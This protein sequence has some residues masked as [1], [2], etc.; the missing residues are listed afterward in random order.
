VTTRNDETATLRERPELRPPGAWSFPVPQT[1]T[2]ATGLAVQAYH[3]PGQFVISAGLSLDVP[4]SAEARDREGVAELTGA[5]LDQGTRSHPSIAFADAVE[6]CGAVLEA[7]V[8]S[9]STQVYLDVPGSHLA[10]ALPL[11]AEAVAEPELTDADV[12][13]EREVRL[14]QI[15]QQLAN[16]SMRADHALRGALFRPESRAARMKSGEP[17][18]L[19]TVTGADVRAFHARHYGPAGGTL[20]LAGDF[21][22]DVRGLVE[23][24]FGAWTNPG[25]V[26][27][28]HEVPLASERVVRLVD[29]PGS[30]QADVRFGRFTINRTDPR[31]ADLQLAVYALGGAFL[32][33]LNSV[34]REEK[35]YT[36]GVHAS[37]TPLRAGGTT[38]ASGSFRNEVVADAVS[39]LGPLL[40]VRDKPLTADEID[41]AR[42]YLVGVQP[43]QYAT[44]SGVCNGVLTLLGAGL[45][46]HFL[47]ELRAAYA[48]VTPESAT[49][50]ASELLRPETMSLV[51][52]GDAGALADGLRGVGYEVEVVSQDA[53]S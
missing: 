30:V 27:V 15:E 38:S 52:V 12:D 47:D 6:C 22:G 49:A 9:S 37:N 18:T 26:A 29:R 20:V 2:L 41:R 13:R 46:P 36:Y 43:L 48:R 40:D 45:T 1:F 21:A 32:S 39:L 51:V 17:D 50:A 5:A 25:Q 33:R 19:R 16:G 34:L 23:D 35:G 7:S 28:R 3:R 42:Q 11:L 31:W 14:A 53:A 24:A 4:L 44:A 10:A 8:G